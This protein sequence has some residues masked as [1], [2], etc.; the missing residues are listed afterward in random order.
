MKQ[1]LV[2]HCDN[3]K[4]HYPL[5]PILYPLASSRTRTLQRNECLKQPGHLRPLI[6]RLARLVSACASIPALKPVGVGSPARC[7]VRFALR[8]PRQPATN[9]QPGQISFVFLPVRPLAGTRDTGPP[10]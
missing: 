4:L 8:A 2:S 7:P 9:L 1:V 6:D 10:T 3:P 5:G